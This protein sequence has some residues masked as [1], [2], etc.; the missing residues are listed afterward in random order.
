MTNNWW[1]ETPSTSRSVEPF[2]YETIKQLKRRGDYQTANELLKK[3]RRNCDE[4]IK[5]DTMQAKR[6]VAR[7][8]NWKFRKANPELVREARR[9][10]NARF[11]ERQKLQEFQRLKKRLAHQ[12]YYLKNKERLSAY[13]KN[14]YRT[15][16]TRMLEYFK[17][18]RENHKQVKANVRR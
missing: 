3:F 17:T 10:Y 1:V 12:R 9:R 7:I 14:Y 11:K 2:N 15:H 8:Q 5:R 16:K 13:S 4:N 18:Y 6:E